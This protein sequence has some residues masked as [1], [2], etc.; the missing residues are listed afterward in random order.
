MITRTDSQPAERQT[1]GVRRTV[2]FALAVLDVDAVQRCTLRALLPAG[3][4]KPRGAASRRTQLQGERAGTNKNRTSTAF[5]Q[6]LKHFERM[7]WVQRTPELVLVR[8]HQALMQHAL[9]D[10]EPADP[11]E[12]LDIRGA[13]ASVRSRT[14]PLS[15]TVWDT[16]TEQRRREVTALK[17]VLQ[18]PAGARVST[19]LAGRTEGNAVTDRSD[20]DGGFSGN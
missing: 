3:E 15:A 16:L 5:T 1:L 11:R 13:L 10:E 7:G 2:A 9:D 4:L 8:D 20:G 12:L 17:R 18:A 6:A 14:R 19:G